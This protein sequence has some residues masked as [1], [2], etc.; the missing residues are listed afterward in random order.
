MSAWQET[1]YDR[2][3]IRSMVVEHADDGLLEVY[4]DQG[5]RD[6]TLT[7]NAY[8]ARKLRLALARFERECKQREGEQP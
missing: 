1:V 3:H 5:N 2:D 7:L 4:V 6:A 8:G